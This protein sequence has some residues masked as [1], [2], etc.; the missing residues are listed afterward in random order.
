[1]VSITTR[2]GGRVW[3]GRGCEGWQAA[4]RNKKEKHKNRFI[5]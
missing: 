2:G 3:V 5:K 4:R 1:M